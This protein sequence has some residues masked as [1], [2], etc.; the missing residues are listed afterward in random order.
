MFI[1]YVGNLEIFDIGFKLRGVDI[2]DEL[3]KFYKVN[4][5]FNFM[6]FV[7]YGRG[8]FGFII[9][10]FYCFRFLVFVCCDVFW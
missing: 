8:K 3:V 7:V 9:I 10:S 1:F 5:F 6:W 2:C 4:Y